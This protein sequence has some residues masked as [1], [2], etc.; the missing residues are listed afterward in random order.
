MFE[1]DKFGDIVGVTKKGRIIFGIILLV[2]VCFITFLCSFTTIKS[3]EV[4]LRIRF[5]KIIDSSL[6]EGINFKIPFVEKIQK[7]NIKVQKVELDV[8][9]STKD[10]Q[11]VGTSTAINYK[12]ISKYASELI[13][14][15]GKDYE[16]TI[17]TPAIKE[18]LKSA[19]AKYNAEEITINR[20]EVSTS[21]LNAIQEK[22]EKYGI[23][24]E[25]FNLTNFNF[26]AEYTKAIEEKQVTEQQVQTAKQKLE[27][28]KI[29]AEEKKVIAEGEAEANKVIEKTLTK[30]ILVQ[31]FIE[32][33]NG[34]LPDT[35]AGQDV[36]SI[37]NLK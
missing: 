37:F 16:E 22:V 6:E 12:V 14:N 27:K 31:Q 8:E 19:I 30:D 11:L 13:R 1:K 5:G 26:S 35:Y 33:W 15:V 23:I 7:V 17:L 10:M 32:K 2:V 34:K 3:G 20:S 28:A 25:E 21:C 36:L 9:A 24:I 4:G 29:E 18:S